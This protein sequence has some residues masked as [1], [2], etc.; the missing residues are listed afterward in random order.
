MK[1][2]TETKR[3][4]LRELTRPDLPLLTLRA[5]IFA[6]DAALRSCAFWLKKYGEKPGSFPA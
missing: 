5:N 3:L 6:G 4:V 2:I 1:T